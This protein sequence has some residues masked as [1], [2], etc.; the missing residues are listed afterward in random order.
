LPPWRQR[1][2]TLIEIIVAISIFAV[3]MTTLYASFNAV[4]GRNEAIEEGRELYEMARNCMERISRD[5]AAVYVERPPLYSVPDIDDPEDPYRLVGEEEPVGTEIFSR[6]RF[7]SNAH[8]PMGEDMQAGICEITYYVEPVGRFEA[9]YVLRRSDTAY[10]YDIDDFEA[11]ETP[12]PILCRGVRAFDVSFLEQEA[13]EGRKQWDS[14][15]RAGKYAT[16][17]AVKIELAVSEGD[18]SYVF[19]TAVILPLYREAIEEERR[20]RK[21]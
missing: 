19:T 5:L 9:E 13:V 8:L 12:D 16:P 14:E 20:R 18:T 2:F 17:R 6:L 10:P 11:D 3:L 4:V 21:G 15:D 1:G 7:A